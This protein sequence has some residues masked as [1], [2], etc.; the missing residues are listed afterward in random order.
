MPFEAPHGWSPQVT[1][2][3]RFAGGLGLLCAFTHLS[4]A[5]VVAQHPLVLGAAGSL[6][7]EQG[8]IIMRRA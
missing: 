8:C 6:L 5:F 3:C 4:Q 1:G 7:N 2:T